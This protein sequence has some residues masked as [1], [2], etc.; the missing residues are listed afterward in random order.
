MEYLIQIFG[1]TVI[2]NSINPDKEFSV[3]FMT[4]AVDKEEEDKTNDKITYKCKSLGE[5]I[6]KEGDTVIKSKLKKKG[7]QSQVLYNRI[8]RLWEQEFS[9]SEKFKEFEDYYS[10]YMSKLIADIDDKLV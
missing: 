3:A 10:M 1:K 6:I 9:G 4:L 5:V 7:S 8:F 2:E